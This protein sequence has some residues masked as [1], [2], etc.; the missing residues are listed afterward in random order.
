M[1]QSLLIAVLLLSTLSVFQNCD[2][3]V[4]LSGSTDLASLSADV[5][6]NPSAPLEV[7]VRNSQSQI[8]APLQFRI[9]LNKV[10]SE[11]VTVNLNTAA[12]TALPTK[13][14]DPFTGNILIPAGQTSVTLTIQTKDPDAELNPLTLTLNI[15]SAS[16]GTV[17]QPSAVGSL[18]PASALLKAKKIVGGA[19]FLCAL[20]LNNDIA[21]AGRV[22][23]Y[24][25]GTKYRVIAG[26]AGAKDVSA[27]VSGFCYVT[28]QNTVKC[29]GENLNGQL[30]NNTQLDSA[31]PVDVVGI[32]NAISI[33]SSFKSSCALLSGGTVRCW[34][35]NVQGQL[36]NNQTSV[37]LV[38][39]NVVNLSGVQALESTDSGFCATVTGGRVFCWGGEAVF[40]NVYGSSSVPVEVA[41][42]NG[43]IALGAGQNHVCALLAD[44]RVRCR[45]RN[46]LGQLG[47]TNLDVISGAAFDVASLSNIRKLAGIG[48]QSCSVNNLGAL[49][50]WGRDTRNSTGGASPAPF[51]MVS[52]GAKDIGLSWDTQCYITLLDNVRC[53]GFNGAGQFGVGTASAAYSSAI[54]GDARVQLP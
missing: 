53:W 22:H 24:S 43:A 45:G 31:T 38:P 51:T 40:T 44:G 17:A 18:Q 39:V 42:L 23:N 7:Y 27:S 25:F 1:K 49:Q 8:G 5:P 29:L 32:A 4:V 14:F 3:K 41:V 11:A 36:G 34:G 6:A 28:A 30:G 47:Q 37:S 21:C 9:E 15:Q 33:S 52:S 2:D 13:N 35:E 50:C 16:A 48:F 20:T 19:N 10:H 54:A 26:S 46:F 12:G